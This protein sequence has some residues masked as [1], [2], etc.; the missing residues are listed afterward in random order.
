MIHISRTSRI[1]ITIVTPFGS[2]DGPRL[3]PRFF[4]AAMLL[5]VSRRQ[6]RASSLLWLACESSVRESACAIRRPYA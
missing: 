2:S 1:C 3:S 6:S 5:N 4:V